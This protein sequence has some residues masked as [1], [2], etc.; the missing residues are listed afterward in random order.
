VSSPDNSS[1]CVD[2]PDASIPSITINI[3]FVENNILFCYN[4]IDSSQKRNMYT[5]APIERAINTEIYHDLYYID[6]ILKK[7]GINAEAKA[8]LEDFISELQKYKKEVYHPSI[9]QQI[10]QSTLEILRYHSTNIPELE[11]YIEIVQRI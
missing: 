10:C 4:Y 9:I 2:F 6:S 11:K 3:D 1:T 8:E 7:K 5:K